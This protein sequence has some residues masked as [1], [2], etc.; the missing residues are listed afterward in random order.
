MSRSRCCAGVRLRA[1]LNYR[2]NVWLDGSLIGN[3]SDTVGTFRYFDF[4]LGDV[5]P[6]SQ[7]VLAVECFRPVDAA[8]PPGNNDTDL[9]IS[10]V[11][12]APPPPDMNM[13]LWREVELTVL[14]GPVSVR[15]PQVTTALSGMEPTQDVDPSGIAAGVVATLTVLLE[16]Q[17]AGDAAVQGKVTV[18]MPSLFKGVLSQP[19]TVEAGATSQVELTPASFPELTVHNPALWW[20]WQMG[21]QTMH[22][23]IIEFVVDGAVSDSLLVPFGMREATSEL[24]SQ[25]YRLYRVNGKALMVRAGGWAPDMF[26][27]I[28]LQR[29]IDEFTCVVLG[30][31]WP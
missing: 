15:Y 2:A 31:D 6:Q 13:G 3:A 28:T 27:R 24:T 22:D 26:Q 12:W 29:Q 11:D 23:L 14:R 30:V 8:F 7:H 21:P 16:L 19:V 25:G 9:A 20:P 17:N 18:S 5:A 4:N 10:F 1:G